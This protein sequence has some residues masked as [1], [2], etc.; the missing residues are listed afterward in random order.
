MLP[1]V[2]KSKD[3]TPKTAGEE[4]RT[5]CMGGRACA[6][7]DEDGRESVRDASPLFTSLVKL[8]VVVSIKRLSAEHL[9]A[10]GSQFER[11]K[12][13]CDRRE[14]AREHMT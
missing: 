14:L 4:G 11:H 8:D 9:V 3:A 1:A 6:R 7:S 12:P 13:T 10:G 2:P 5:W